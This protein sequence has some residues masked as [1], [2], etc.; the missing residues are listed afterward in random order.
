MDPDV[1]FD[2]A[3]LTQD[4]RDYLMSKIDSHTG[5]VDNDGCT[6]YLAKS[7]AGKNSEVGSIYTSREIGKIFGLK[8]QNLNPAALKYSLENMYAIRYSDKGV[9]ECSH[10][11][12]FGKC[13]SSD[14][15]LMEPK[16]VNNERIAHHQNKIV[17]VG[18]ISRDKE[19]FPP[20]IHKTVKP[21]FA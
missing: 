3:V 2:P 16:E 6:A 8:Q 4:Q 20:C 11:C 7:T 5:S 19:H 13:L 10:L 18:H 1:R 14:H 15:I 9:V 21:S 12:G 17:C